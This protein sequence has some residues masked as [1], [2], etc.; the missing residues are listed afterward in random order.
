M[1]T[2]S[3]CH[4]KFRFQRVV[5]LRTLPSTARDQFIDK[6]QLISSFTANL[7]SVALHVGKCG[8]GGLPPSHTGLT[9]FD[10]DGDPRTQETCFNFLIWALSLWMLSSCVDLQQ[11]L[12][13]PGDELAMIA[14]GAAGETRDLR[15]RPPSDDTSTVKRI[16]RDVLADQ[17]ALKRRLHNVEPA[18]NKH[19]D[20]T[21]CNRLFSVREVQHDSAM[22]KTHVSH[23]LTADTAFG[24]VATAEE[25][26]FPLVGSRGCL[27][28]TIIGD[29]CK[30][31]RVLART[32]CA[33]SGLSLSRVMLKT[34]VKKGIDVFLFP[35]GGKIMDALGANDE[36]KGDC[37]VLA[38]LLVV[39]ECAILPHVCEGMVQALGFS[40][41]SFRL[42][43]LHCLHKV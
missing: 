19:L 7:G 32:V 28:T 16:L 17:V 11:A 33:R 20:D 9:N 30:G 41:S 15:V 26:V 21:A 43:H 23:V 13:D 10:D 27:N 24:L 31:M 40:I 6:G 42:H 38:C 37:P 22:G 8:S 2:Y 3:H 14:T 35:V 36:C 25:R 39:G 1:P 29:I 4:A 5:K 12:A 18:A 34:S